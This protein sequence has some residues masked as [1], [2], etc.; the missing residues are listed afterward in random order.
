MMKRTT[1]LIADH[2]HNLRK[3][4]REFF[5]RLPNYEVIGELE[6][7]EELE[8]KI[9]ELQPDLLI[10]DIELPVMNGIEVA[11]RVRREGLSTHVFVTT[12]FEDPIYS[13]Q[14]LE[15]GARGVITKSQLKLDLDSK[16]KVHG[17]VLGRQQ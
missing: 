4:I 6:N 9:R 12:M 17:I 2:H 5:H 7:G 11:R 16:F 14:A 10:V 13:A 3:N 8:R 1:V 15:A